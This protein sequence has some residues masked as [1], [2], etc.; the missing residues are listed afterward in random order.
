MQDT[1]YWM[2]DAGYWMLDTRY[3]MESENLE[4]FY[5]VEPYP[6]SRIQY[7]VSLFL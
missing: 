6:V 2:L 4:S 1:G 3:W 5:I 7:Q